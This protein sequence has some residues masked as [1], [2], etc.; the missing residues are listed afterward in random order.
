MILGA[1]DDVGGRAYL[2]QQAILNPGPYM[3]LLGKVLPQQVDAQV[4]HR[5][6]ARIPSISNDMDEWDHQHASKLNNPQTLQ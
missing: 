3:S 6:V 1:L 5:Y 4:E 2:A